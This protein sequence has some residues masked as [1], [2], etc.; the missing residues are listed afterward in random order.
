MRVG[1]GG[2]DWSRGRGSYALLSHRPALSQ[3]GILTGLH[4]HA[5]ARRRHE[6]GVPNE[7]IPLVRHQ[8]DLDDDAIG[9]DLR[10]PADAA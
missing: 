6:T 3:G 7:T 2:P 10:S 8:V 4:K 5:P 1:G 9:A